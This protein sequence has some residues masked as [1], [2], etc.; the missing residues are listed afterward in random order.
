[1]ICPKC[2]SCQIVKAGT[3]RGKPALLCKECG[4]QFV[5]GALL[6]GRPKT[7]STPPCPHCSRETRKRGRDGKGRQR[8]ECKYCKRIS[9]IPLHA[10]VGTP[11]KR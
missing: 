11:A 7:E 8:Y 4:Y 5:A 3:R 6:A 2:N 10:R 9:K 1:M